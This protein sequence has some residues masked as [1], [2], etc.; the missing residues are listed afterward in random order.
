MF[1]N[2]GG[3]A[4]QVTE[5]A[6][7]NRNSYS[8]GCKIMSE[9]IGIRSLSLLLLAAVFFFS[10]AS[11]AQT[12]AEE[13]Q[14]TNAGNYNVQQTVEVGYREDW[15]NGNQDTYDTFVDLGTG[16]RLLD[17]TLNMRS[18]NHQGILFDNLNFSN[19]GYGGDPDD[20]SRLRI[21]KNKLYDFSLVFRRD[22]NFWDYNLLANPLNPVPL[23]TA[24]PVSR[25]TP[26]SPFL[27]SPS[28]HSPH[29]LYLVRRMQ[30][31]D[32]TL[33]PQS[34][35]RFRLGYSRDVNEGPSLSSFAGTTEFPAGTEFPDDHER[36]SHGRGFPG[37]AEDDDFL[38]SVP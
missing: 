29:S 25:R 10:P 9:R 6:G 4:G 7:G 1:A 5:L 12:S 13:T 23:P 35:V 20:V 17:Y 30:D 37:S 32:L 36:V 11:R 22:K 31:Y 16:L 28:N 14:G 26:R 21:E 15:I 24:S 34:R 19:F 27:R 18:L 38:R 2:V 8:S 3:T 33:L